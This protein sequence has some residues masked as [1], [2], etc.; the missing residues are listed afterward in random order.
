MNKITKILTVSAMAVSLAA[1]GG[2]NTPKA[3]ENQT[4]FTIMGG[5]SALSPGYTDN[6]VLNKMA[7]EAGITIEWNTMSDSL[8]E[9]VNI[10]NRIKQ[11]HGR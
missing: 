3:D 5:Q 6:E 7:E 8:A 11:A 1:C 2:S 9:Q 10:H 4:A